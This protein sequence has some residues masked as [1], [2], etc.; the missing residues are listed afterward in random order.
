MCPVALSRQLSLQPAASC[1]LQFTCQRSRDLSS[2]CLAVPRRVQPPLDARALSEQVLKLSSEV[3][4][5]RRFQA[6]GE[7]SGSSML[8][9]MREMKQRLKRQDEAYAALKRVRSGGR[10]CSTIKMVSLLRHRV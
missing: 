3:E 4:A 1:S 10:L 6:R 2:V 8:T 5:R 9:Q 7:E